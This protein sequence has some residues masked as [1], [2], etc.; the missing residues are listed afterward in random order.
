MNFLGR[1][2][3]VLTVLAGLVLCIIYNTQLNGLLAD[4]GKRYLFIIA[5]AGLFSSLGWWFGYHYDR[6]KFWAEKDFLTG[7]YNRRYVYGIFPKLASRMTREGQKLSI[8]L[9]DIDDFKQIN[10]TMGHQQGDRIIRMVS[11]KIEDL[12]RKTDIVARW[13]GDE[14]LMVAPQTDIHESE[15]LMNRIQSELK[16]LS[17][18]SSMT[19][20]VSAGNA[21]YPDDARTLDQLIK[22]A[23]RRMYASK[24]Q[25]KSEHERLQH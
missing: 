20:A 17:D 4:D 12:T 16:A 24:A 14:I 13:G 18:Q 9:I 10:D 8:F 21:I 7:A 11:E 23:D 19:L 25:A 3:S 15:K 1:K 5:A 2:L 6:A 22:E